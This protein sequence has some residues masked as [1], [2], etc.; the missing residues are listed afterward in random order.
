MIELCSLKT[1]SNVC[2]LFAQSKSNKKSF[3]LFKN[4]LFALTRLTCNT[5]TVKSGSRWVFGVGSEEIALGLVSLL[6]DS[7]SDGD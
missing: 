2:F 4:V 7:S 1:K 3:S 6:K 5:V